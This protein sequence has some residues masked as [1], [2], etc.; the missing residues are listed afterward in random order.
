MIRIENRIL[1]PTA[2]NTYLSCPRKYYLRYIK[3][4]STRSSIHLIRG[5]VVHKTLHQFHINM[6]PGPPE[7]PLDAIQKTL[8]NAFNTEWQKAG[9]RLDALKMS[10]QDIDFYRRDSELMLLNFSHWFIKNNRPLPE[11]CESRI[12]SHKLKI[13]GIIDAILSKDSR[14][15]L[16]D[17][18]TSKYARVTDDIRRQAAIYALLYADKYGIMPRAVWIH[19]LK[20]PDDPYP[21]HIDEA[22]LQYGKIVI[23]SVREK[24][25]SQNEAH[26]PCTCGGYCERDFVMA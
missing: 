17:Y 3:R 4:L 9:T 16:I 2:I 18:K 5:L 20:F 21:I 10:K 24:T 19:F 11:A 1:S 22:I 26:Y 15:I 8:L 7:L 14:V 23:E 13:M 6:P 12:F 25:R